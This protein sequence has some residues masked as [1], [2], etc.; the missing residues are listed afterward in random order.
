MTE[1]RQYGQFVISLELF[2]SRTVNAEPQNSRK[3]FEALKKDSFPLIVFYS[4]V[5]GHSLS[6]LTGLGSKS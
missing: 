3:Q 5:C 4:D 6:M 2:D 1:V